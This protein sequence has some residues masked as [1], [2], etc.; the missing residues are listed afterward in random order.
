MLPI[1]PVLFPVRPTTLRAASALKTSISPLLTQS[2]QCQYQQQRTIKFFKK[3]DF[4]GFKFK[5]DPPGHIIGTVN[6]PFVPPPPNEYHGSYHWAYEKIVT[7]TMIP[8]MATPI[9]TGIAVPPAVDALC[10][11]LLLL[12]AKAGFTSCIV[13]YIP[14]RKFGSWHKLALG[15]LS[16]GTW[17]GIYGVYVI[18]T[19]ENGIFNLLH[20]VWVS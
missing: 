6:E 1:R 10:G 8:L 9:V 12:H 14:L 18:E 13:D 7:L 16:L 17:L 15:L 19:E 11:V 4:S 2:Y 20:Q 3:P 5:S